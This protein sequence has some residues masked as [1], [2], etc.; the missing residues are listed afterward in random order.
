MFSI[1]LHETRLPFPGNLPVVTHIPSFQTADKMTSQQCVIAG[2]KKNNCIPLIGL[3]LF[4]NLN[5]ANAMRNRVAKYLIP[6]FIFSLL[7][8]IPKFFESEIEYQDEATFTSTTTAAEK[9]TEASINVTFEAVN[10]TVS[11]MIA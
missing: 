4:Q 1:I 11:K 8:N 10:D 7:F 9:T 6:V 5:N 3:V 2:N